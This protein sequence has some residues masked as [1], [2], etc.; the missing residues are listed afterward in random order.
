MIVLS[1]TINQLARL[2][3]HLRK[4]GV[5]WFLLMDDD[6]LKLA[7]SW[8]FSVLL[9]VGGV[10]EG[11]DEGG[12]RVL[13]TKF[14]VQWY[15]FQLKLDILL[16]LATNSLVPSILEWQNSN[17]NISNDISLASQM[18]KWQKLELTNDRMDGH[19]LTREDCV[20]YLPS[21]ST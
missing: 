14:I 1:L 13:K 8:R 20:I 4:S 19:N 9:A 11:Q 7:T 18:L 2:F 5:I 17:N 15:F 10:V 3:C 6:H 16:H 12:F 21:C